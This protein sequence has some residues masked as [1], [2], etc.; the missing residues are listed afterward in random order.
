MIPD[1]Q[2]VKCAVI[3]LFWGQVILGRSGRRKPQLA[4]A[5]KPGWSLVAGMGK[6]IFDKCI[7]AESIKFLSGLNNFVPMLIVLKNTTLV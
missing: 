3:T 4:K 7:K 5:A 2:I 6:G 1:L